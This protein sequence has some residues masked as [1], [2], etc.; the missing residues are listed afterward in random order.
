MIMT[1]AKLRWSVSEPHADIQSKEQ[2]DRWLDKLSAATK[3]EYPSIVDVC[4][5]GYQVGIGIGLP[6]SFV[7]VEQDNGE[8]P[9]MVT[10]GDTAAGGGLQ[11]LE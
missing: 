1:T 2:L 8:G 6:Q 5:H 10:V 3:P 11:R 4:V 9:Y 7:H